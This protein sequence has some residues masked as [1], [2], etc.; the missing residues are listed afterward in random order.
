MIYLD[1]AATTPLAPE[2]LD[3]MRPWMEGRCANPSSSHGPGVRA[4][5]ALDDASREVAGLAGGEGRWDVVFTSGGSESNALALLGTARSARRASV[6]TSA[7][8]HPSVLR[9]VARLVDAGASVRR[10]VPGHDGVVDPGSLIDLVDE[11]TTIVSLMLANNEIGTLQPVCQVAAAVKARSPGTL[12]HV[13]AVQAAGK[14]PLSAELVAVDLVSLSAH[15]MHGPMGVGALLIRRGSRRPAPLYAGG[16]Q[17]SGLRPGTENVPGIVGF[18]AAARLATAAPEQHVASLHDM[19][20]AFVD[21]LGIL[22]GCAP[23]FTDA[24]RLPGHVL[25]LVSGVGAQPV[26]HAMEQRGFV[27]SSGSACHSLTPRRS[28]VMDALGLPADVQAIRIVA[29][30]QNTRAQMSDA[31]MALREVV[32]RLR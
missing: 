10:V 31:G 28:H 14:I 15:K 9:N 4:A 5:R 29:S 20:R 18:G 13:D 17:Q 11:K 2:A 1:N 7:I 25:V 23:G 30:R 8:E 6:V 19:S 21:A 27:I 12:V 32:T 16:D 24:P 22:E 3:A 26:M